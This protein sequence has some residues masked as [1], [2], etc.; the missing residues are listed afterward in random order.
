MDF[1]LSGKTAVVTGGARGIG[2]AVCS[3]LA[4]EGA[5]VGILD[6]NIEG[7]EET[8]RLIEDNSGK[9]LA[10]K[11]D[12]ANYESVSMAF[13][14]VVSEFGPVDV[15]V[16]VAAITDNM[17]TIKKMELRNWKREIAVNLSGAFYSIK[18]VCESMIERKWG[19]LIFISSRAGLDGGFGQCAYASSKMGLIALAKTAAWEFARMG[20]TSNVVF[21][22][23]VDTPAT[24]ALPKD[25][26]QRIIAKNTMGRLQ[27][28]DELAYTVTYLASEQSKGVNGA[29][30]MVN[31]GP[32]KFAFNL[33]NLPGD[34]LAFQ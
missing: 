12:L 4:E 15:M 19:R 6:L 18:Q 32:Q 8:A 29:E 5:N 30:I 9:A 1:K 11:V 23:L 13:K 34:E 28:P 21:P 7:A 24:Q 31:M 16:Y 22:G 20:I 26:M 33:M 10:V 3:V 27:N 2:R 14:K 25:V 17:A